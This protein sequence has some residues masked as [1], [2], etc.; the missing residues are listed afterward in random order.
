M[1]SA[2]SSSRRR[3]AISASG[4]SAMPVISPSHGARSREPQRAQLHRQ[5]K[6]VLGAALAEHEAAV[7][8]AEREGLAQILKLHVLRPAL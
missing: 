6:T 2:S 1:G 4:V 3:I 7:T 8:V 5:A